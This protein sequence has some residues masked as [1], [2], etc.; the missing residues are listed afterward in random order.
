MYPLDEVADADDEFRLQ[1]VDALH[2]L[3][4]DLRPMAAGA[5]GDDRELELLHVGV[6]LQARPR[7]LLFRSGP[8]A[9]G[10]ADL[11]FVGHLRPRQRDRP[12]DDHTHADQQ[13][14]AIHKSTQFGNGMATGESYQNGALAV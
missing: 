10:L 6:H 1:H 8:D 13:E 12:A 7:I 4:E 9:V 11:C 2:R 3:A 5:V 14:N